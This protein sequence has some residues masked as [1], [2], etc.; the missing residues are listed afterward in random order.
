MEIARI[1]DKSTVL[2]D[3]LLKFKE[4]LILNNVEEIEIII[5]N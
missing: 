4:N 1:Y 2:V 3:E 5:N